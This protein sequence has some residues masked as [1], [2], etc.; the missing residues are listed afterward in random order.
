MSM[1]TKLSSVL[2][3]GE[4]FLFPVGIFLFKVNN[5][6]TRIESEICPKLTK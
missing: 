1:I 4:T 5:K 2:T 3:Y 6:N